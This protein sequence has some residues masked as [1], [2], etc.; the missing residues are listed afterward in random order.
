MTAGDA[1][2]F[3]GLQRAVALTLSCVIV[4]GPF[5]VGGV[6]GPAKCDVPGQ[7]SPHRVAWNS[8]KGP[9]F[10]SGAQVI[11]NFAVEP[12]RPEFMYVT[13]GESVMRT[14][15]GGCHWQHAYSLPASGGGTGVGVDN[16]DI[17][18]IEVSG[19][20]V[21]YLPIQQQSPAGPRP[22]LM[23]SRDAGATWQT[24]EGGVLG[25][26]FGRFLDFDAPIAD[27]SKAYAFVDIE[28]GEL[29]EVRVDTYQAL[30][31]TNDAGGTWTNR[32]LF[33]DGTEIQVAGAGITIAAFEGLERITADPLRGEEVW[34]YGGPETIRSTSTANLPVPSL[35]DIGELDISVDGSMI[36]AYQKTSPQ[37]H[38]S[39][40]GGQEFN[41]FQTGIVVGSAA[42][43][44]AQY[45]GPFGAAEAM[46]RTFFHVTP[47][48]SSKVVPLE[49]TAE[50]GTRISGIQIGISE[51]G[52]NG[53]PFEPLVI[54][55]TAN[56][57]EV[58]GLPRLPPPPDV[59]DEIISDLIDPG[60]NRP[61]GVLVPRTMKLKLRPGEAASVP[62][63]LTVPASSTPLDVYFLIDI[64]GSMGGT[65]DGVRSAMQEIVDR[66]SEE[67]T[68]VNF[69]VGAFRAYGDPPAYA[70]LRNIGPVNGEL[71]RALNSLDASGG[72]AETQMS[73][74]YQSV[75]GEGEPGIPPDLQ[76][77]FR[78]GSLRVAILS[79]DEVISQG[80]QHKPVPVV[81]D[82]LKEAD[83]KQVAL[84]IQEGPVVGEHDY[85]NPGEPAN[86]LRTVAEGSG[87]VAPEGGVDCDG[88]GGPEIAEGDPIVCIM[89]PGESSE[90]D[91][92]AD[93]IVNVLNAVQD[94][95]DV[96]I[97]VA[98]SNAAVQGDI[99]ES[100]TPSAFPATDLK[101][102]HNLDFDV[103]VRCP[104][105]Q[106]RTVFPLDVAVGTS[107]ITLGSADLI[108]VC[109]PKVKPEPSPP[110]PP[111]FVPLLALPF[112]PVRPPEPI[113]EPNPN[114]QPN[115]QGNPQAQAG[116][117]S[118]EQK[119]PQLA[120]VHQE[121]GQMELQPE[122]ENK[123]GD[124]FLMT[125]HEQAQ[126]IQPGAVFVTGAVLMT[127]IYGFATMRREQ[128][129][130]QHQRRKPWDD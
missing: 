79:T 127:L 47:P 125:A 90:A 116:M 77:D 94:I 37:G 56:T 72:G 120:A 3:R 96:A 44:T 25:G 5:A 63:G 101:Q 51:G 129:R 84:A 104:R 19:P 97:Q 106:D 53:L 6:A 103:T 71:S 34:L 105:V 69:G 23:V 80:G 29:P 115:P 15:D 27:S 88:D 98:R 100:V 124:Q 59:P 114:P 22:R 26:A 122:S 24:A 126:G 70:R 57:I 111:P 49:M 119:Q 62:Y 4:L 54:G 10:P 55:H 20:G 118:Q 73:A 108:V 109:D 86:T 11:A 81:I 89:S 12:L 60:A 117:A 50:N 43:I 58:M 68:D 61:P 99:V 9:N 28:N 35:G 32:T 91:I 87:A 41:A 107:R 31:E 16:S 8:I 65:I 18:E 123:G 113:P 92:M 42:A 67:G 21:V 30:L 14:T 52:A 128:L 102:P 78:P 48:G 83:V 13:N 66:L 82:A 64:S 40:D 121:S 110:L 45:G 7:I 2:S 130:T 39:V 74:L 95:Q 85:E 46:G 112:P 33:D 76:M 75:T 36:V 38:V 93:A 1:R 17:L